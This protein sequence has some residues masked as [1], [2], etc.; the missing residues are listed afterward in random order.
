MCRRFYEIIRD[1]PLL[2]YRLHLAAT[3]MEDLP[4]HFLTKPD[5]IPLLAKYHRHRDLETFIANVTAIEP[6]VVRLLA[7]PAWEFAS[8]VLAQT[9]GPLRIEF[10]QLSSRVNGVQPKTWGLELKKGIRDF[11][12]DP[13][14]DLLVCMQAHRLSE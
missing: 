3:G 9:A 14:Q 5:K 8:G 6:E 2:Q 12:M 11:T 1:A 7:G 4:D 13:G 10:R